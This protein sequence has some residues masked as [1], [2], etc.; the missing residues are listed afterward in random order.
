M[1]SR[2]KG[3]ARAAV[4]NATSAVVLAAVLAA[5]VLSAVLLLR[6]MNAAN[7]INAK[8]MNKKT[9]DAYGHR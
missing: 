1:S 3:A 2:L 4:T 9:A 5:T 7:R 8:A 6:T